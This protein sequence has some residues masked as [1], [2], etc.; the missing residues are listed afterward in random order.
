MR[1]HRTNQ[2]SL[3]TT[4]DSSQTTFKTDFSTFDESTKDETP[5]KQITSTISQIDENSST[6]R[7]DTS[8]NTDSSFSTETSFTD[9]TSFASFSSQSTI[10]PITTQTLISDQSSNPITTSFSTTSTYSES[11]FEDTTFVSVKPIEKTLIYECTFDSNNCNV[12]L[13]NKKRSGKIG[14]VQI[15]AFDDND[16]IIDVSKNGI[17]KFFFQI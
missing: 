15:V 5:F 11:T 16:T 17:K 1:I 7:P 13:K 8:S 4:H 12:T 2:L 3:S 14:I 6:A 9:S 10:K